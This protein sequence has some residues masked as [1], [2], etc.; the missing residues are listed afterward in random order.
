MDYQPKKIVVT[1]IG[2]RTPLGRDPEEIWKKVRGGETSIKEVYGTHPELQR[3]GI[4]SGSLFEGYGMGMQRFSPRHFDF[5]HEA[6]EI[7]KPEQYLQIQQLALTTTKQAIDNSKLD[8]TQINPYR[9][10]VAVG[11]GMVDIPKILAEWT[12]YRESDG[13]KYDKL[14]LPKVLP[15][16]IPGTLSQQWQFHAGDSPA[17]STACASGASAICYGGDLIRTGD[18]DIVLCSAT[19]QV[20]NLP[21]YVGF[22]NLRSLSMNQNPDKACRPFDVERD[23]LVMAE[24]S[25]AIILEEEQHAKERNAHIYGELAG[26]ARFTDGFHITKPNPEVQALTMKE[27]LRKAG[28]SPN[29]IDY[30]NAHGTST[31]LGDK[32]ESEAIV[33]ALGEDAQHIPVTS[34]KGATGH[35]FGTTGILEAIFTL[36]AMRDS[37]A[38]PTRNFGEGEEIGERKYRLN[39][40][41]NG[42]EKT[43]DTAVT[44]S[45]GFFGH[46]VSLLLRKAA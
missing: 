17:I 2:A 23:G 41:P 39:H 45:F 42:L 14:F 44:N 31:P 11:V 24:G 33:D 32:A 5:D 19:T 15:D 1:G 40:C 43:I 27:T 36:Q 35:M 6:F 28:A 20:D 7:E 46:D 3:V 16:L 22:K 13:R 9:A 29:E 21:S 38:P 18:A 8:L 12:K 26:Y 4:P 25:A 37:Y 34:T 10:G 30:I